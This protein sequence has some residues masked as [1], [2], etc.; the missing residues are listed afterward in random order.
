MRAW[1]HPRRRLLLGLL[2]FVVTVRVALPYI[3]RP[4]IVSQ[5]NAALI[6]R[7]E[8]ANLDLSL[9]R[10]GLTLHGLEVHAHERPPEPAAG[11][12]PAQTEPP[13]FDANRLWV[14]IS[15]LELLRKTI[16]VEEFELEGFAIRL[17]RLLDG[18]VLPNAAPSDDSEEPEPA[19]AKEDPSSWSFAAESAA[20]R[21]GR[22]TFRDFT[23]G[24]PPQTFD[25][26]VR[27]LSAR[28]L[29]LVIDPT[30][31][32]PGHLVISAQI[33][34]GSV[35]LDSQIDS[36]PEGPS[37]VSTITLANFP[38]GGIRPYLTMFGWSELAG[39]FDAA[40]THRYETGGANEVGGTVSLSHVAVTV[41]QL[42]QP[43]LAWDK[44]AIGLDKVDLV[45]QHAGVSTVA[46]QGGRVAV[47]LRAEPALPLMTPP[48]ATRSK[49]PA[50]QPT[51]QADTAAK[52]WHWKIATVRLSDAQVDLLGDGGPLPLGVEA[53]L[54]E[55]SSQAGGRWPIQLQVTQGAGTFGI[56][57]SIAVAPMAFE[58]KVRVSEFALPPILERM[59]VAPLRLLRQA[60]ARADLDLALTPASEQDPQAAAASTDLRVA[61]TLGLAGLEVGV[62]DSEDFRAR[63]QDL[64]IAIAE[65]RIPR[66][67]GPAEPAAQREVALKLDRVRLVEPAL[68][69]TREAD[70]L[71]LPSTGT[72]AEPASAEPVTDAQATEPTEPV[73]AAAP[74]PQVAV[75][76]TDLEVERASAEVLDRSVQPFYR[77]RIESLD[78]RARGLNWPAGT[79]DD[80]ALDLQG[81]HGAALS[82]RGAV[83]PGK[84]KINATLDGLPLA[85]F[86]PYVAASGYALSDGALSLKT[87]VAIRR[88]RYESS[89]DLKVRQLA[90][91]GAE[92]ESR[93]EQNFGIPL[94]LALALLTD[95]NGD[96]TLTVPVD[97][98]RKGVEVDFGTIVRQALA[99]ALMGA[100]ASPLKLLGAVTSGG[101]VERLAPEPILF[102]AGTAEMVA[103]GTARL[104]Q[105][106]S[107]LAASPGLALSL[108]GVSAPADHRWHQ[109]QTLLEELRN[110]SGIRALGQIGQIGTRR[111][112]RSYLEARAAG[113]ETALD[114]EEQTWFEEQVAAQ[115]VAPP[116]LEA[117][118]HARASAARDRLLSQ[119]GIAAE[120]LTIGPATIEQQTA[121][122]SVRISLGSPARSTPDTGKGP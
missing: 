103:D 115:S 60:V 61:G 48:N 102:V 65:L 37:V 75:E 24:D 76:L 42:A 94:S 71:A 26:A 74:V 38:I 32:E 41:P 51:S 22:I 11:E 117:L 92:G 68:R 27:D 36:R 122:P 31:R 17:D 93:F 97:A 14:Q 113:T 79:V 12:T 78:L 45:G 91:G 80:L 66:L 108:N 99:K 87:K 35:D 46:L 106:A 85:P 62:A 52:P 56:E 21:D 72:A 8:L 88:E 110:T 86:N 15:W 114:P 13:I 47:D 2:A 111:A 57:G 89:T 43:A 64:D 95:L 49:P 4:V 55:L 19:A 101:K 20:C 70:G 6:G 40:I 105:I 83:I 7:I 119:H 5:A 116:K 9:L 82:V 63:W 58:G 29:A 39:T 84:S 104:E 25:F 77:G 118:A 59:D 23:V 34:E 90:V 121:S 112:V 1:R 81:L 28:D 53:E 33:G 18:I 100:L 96:I 44:L 107:L 69:L 16:E 67:L 73:A 54:K 3:L 30:G 120:R 98:G 109:E 50:P 10:G